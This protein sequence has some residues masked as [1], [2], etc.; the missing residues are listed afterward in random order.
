[1]AHMHRAGRVGR[2]VFDVHRRARA[3]PAAAK[4]IGVDHGGAQDLVQ[5]L[6][7]RA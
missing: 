6:R 7:A 5:N 2:D 3:L 1:M 4:A